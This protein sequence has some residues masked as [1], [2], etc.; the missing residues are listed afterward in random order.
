MTSGHMER[1]VLDNLG[2]LLGR[3]LLEQSLG[4]ER[5]IIEDKRYLAIP[6]NQED[7]LENI[8]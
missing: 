5:H 2:H 6:A 1:Q 7:K 3:E 8:S 4:E